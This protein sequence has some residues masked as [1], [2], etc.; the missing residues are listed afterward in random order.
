[1]YI[2]IYT[3]IFFFGS[4]RTSI[5]RYSTWQ[6]EEIRIVSVEFMCVETRELT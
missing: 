6:S 3:Y 2:Y 5:S 1:M 4:C